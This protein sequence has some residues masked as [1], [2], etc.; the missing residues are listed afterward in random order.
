M[1]ILPSS[2]DKI[3]LLLLLLFVE[4]PSF[5]T[6]LLYVNLKKPKYAVTDAQKKCKICLEP[7]NTYD[8]MDS[9]AVVALKEKYAENVFF[10]W[11]HAFR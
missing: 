7:K 2:N 10:S 6:L 4:S 1:Y 5:K 3:E 8:I 9:Y 11:E